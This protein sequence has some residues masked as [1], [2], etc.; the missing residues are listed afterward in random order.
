LLYQAISKA[1]KKHHFLSASMSKGCHFASS[2][3]QSACGVSVGLK[4]TKQAI[5]IRYPFT[6]SQLPSEIPNGTAIA[7]W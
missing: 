1:D 6:F 5:K 2:S 7:S 3:T 4:S